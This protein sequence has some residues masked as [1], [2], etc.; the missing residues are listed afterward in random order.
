MKKLPGWGEKTSALFT[1]TIYQIHFCD[2]YNE[3]KIW[4]DTP[5]LSDNDELFLPVD[6]VISSVFRELAFFSTP[7]FQ[8][9]N[10]FLKTNFS[11]SQIEVWDDLWFWGFM[12]Q[13]GSGN[14]RLHTWNEN[15]YWALRHSDK[16]LKM[17]SEI[18]EKSKD[19]LNLITK[20]R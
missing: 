8:T 10:K 6:H 15:K 16:D 12:T 17:I 7:N 20:N 13:K 9:V 18:K 5:Q 19:F 11:N 3:F 4:E 14:N 1:K 2:F